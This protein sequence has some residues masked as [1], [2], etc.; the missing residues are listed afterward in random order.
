M[1]LDFL[2]E[3]I[4]E[5]GQ[6]PPVSLG[7]PRSVVRVVTIEQWMEQCIKRRFAG[8]E[9]DH[10]SACRKA[11]DRAADKLRELHLIAIMDGYA[12]IIYE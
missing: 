7:L 12:W 3:A 11:F 6:L 4:N 8:G 1:A 2:V 10:N 5:V 9:R